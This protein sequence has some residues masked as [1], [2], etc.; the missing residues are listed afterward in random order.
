MTT[1]TTTTTPATKLNGKARKAL[2][3]QAKAVSVPTEQAELAPAPTQT[4]Q[5]EPEPTQ[6]EATPAKAKKEKVKKEKLAGQSVGLTTKVGVI[7]SWNH[8]LF[9]NVQLA[10]VNS[11]E[12]PPLTDEQLMDAMKAEFPLRTYFQPVKRIRSW[13]NCGRYGQGPMGRAS[14]DVRQV[15]DNR[16]VEYKAKT[17]TE[18][19]S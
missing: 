19:K 12:E 6:P 4:V 13:Y 7:E 5:P 3:K 14:A 18:A 10:K 8:F 1:T 16:S 2:K 17:E 15:G 9:T 11:P